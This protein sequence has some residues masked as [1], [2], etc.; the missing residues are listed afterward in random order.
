ME[1][2]ENDAYKRLTRNH[3]KQIHFIT[4]WN[5]LA[6]NFPQEIITS[7]QYAMFSNFKYI[8]LVIGWSSEIKITDTFILHVELSSRVSNFVE[9]RENQ[10]WN[11]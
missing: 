11:F 1:N 2:S 6:T 4:K 9:I 8:S 3:Q 5:S 7:W 10:V